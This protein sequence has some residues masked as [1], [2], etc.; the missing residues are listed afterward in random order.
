MV[1]WSVLIHYCRLHLS[2][3]AIRSKPSLFLVQVRDWV[4]SWVFHSIPILLAKG[5]EFICILG[6][7]WRSTSFVPPAP[8]YCGQVCSGAPGGLWGCRTFCQGQGDVSPV[9]IGVH[10]EAASTL[11][12]GQPYL[13]YGHP[14]VVLGWKWDMGTLQGTWERERSCGCDSLSW[15]EMGASV[16]GCR[17]E[18]GSVSM[19]PS[20]L[21]D[22][23]ASQD[24]ADGLAVPGSIGE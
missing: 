10:W 9:A 19:S 18:W 16:L 7:G 22:S 3:G 13:Q 1:L 11:A 20:D 2:E 17:V 21:W 14:T 12:L 23:C 4:C 5:L 15:E 24:Q 8:M 6:R